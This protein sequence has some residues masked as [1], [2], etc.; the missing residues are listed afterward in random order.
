M[1][2]GRPPQ[3]GILVPR[4]VL[5]VQGSHPV[6]DDDEDED[7]DMDEEDEEVAYQDDEELDAEDDIGVGSME[8]HDMHLGGDGASSLPAAPVAPSEPEPSIARCPLPLRLICSAIL[9]AFV[10][11]WTRE[12]QLRPAKG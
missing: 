8:V 11:P 12:V 3:T 2:V 7:D 10:V 5:P 1:A 6:Q 9:H 4:Y